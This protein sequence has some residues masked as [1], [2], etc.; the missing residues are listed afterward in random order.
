MSATSFT[1]PTPVIY[2][3]TPMRLVRWMFWAFVLMCVA[4]MA[5]GLGLF[6]GLPVLGWRLWPVQ[7]TDAAFKDLRLA[8]KQD[9]VQIVAE[10]YAHD[11]DELAA[12]RRIAALC[13]LGAEAV[14]AEAA[15]F[16]ADTLAHST[17]LEATRLAQLQEGYRLPLN[18]SRLPPCPNH[19]PHLRLH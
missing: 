8:D 6:I 1:H 12:Q 10:V 15:Q 5:F 11:A 17:G 3:V 14:C 4:L 13:G 9:Y 18:N 2:P 7:W 19:R 16:V